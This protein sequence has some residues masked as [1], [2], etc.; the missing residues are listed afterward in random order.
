M[1]LYLMDLIYRE[2]VRNLMLLSKSQRAGSHHLPPVGIPLRNRFAAHP[3]LS[4]AGLAA[5]VGDL[6][7][8]HGALL[9]HKSHHSGNGVNMSVRP[10]ADIK[11]G[12]ASARFHGCGL[13]YDEPCAA[14]GF[15][16]QCDQLPII[17]KPIRV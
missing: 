4:G 1:L 8:R 13:K 6:N 14:S 11:R 3:R 16:P 15:G 10:N 17:G 2:F 12:D 5:S 7:A 9:L